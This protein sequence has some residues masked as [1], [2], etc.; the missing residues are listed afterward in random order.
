MDS[1][2]TTWMLVS[3]AF[4]LLMTPGLAFFYGGLVRQRQTVN[5]IKMSFVALGIIAIEWAVLGYSMAFAPGSAV[6]G[7]L[8]FLGLSGVT[9]E[10][11]ARYAEG[12]P[13]LAF[14]A[15]Q[16]M[17]A[18]ITPALI[19]GAVVGRMR[20]KAYALFILLWGIVVYNPVAHWVWGPGGFLREIGALDFAGGTVVHVSAGVSALVVALVLGPRERSSADDSLAEAPHNVPFVILGAAL[21]WFGWFGFNAGSAL[22][23]NGVAALALVTTMLSASAALVTWV[24]V[25]TVRRDKPTATGAAVA[26][27]VGLVAITPGAGFVAP[28][29]AIAVGSIAALAS[30][31]AIEIFKRI[32]RTR[33]DDTLDVFAC[34]GV[35]GIVGCILTGVFATTTVNGAGADGLFY[36][37]GRLLAVQA[38]SVAVAGLYASAATFCVLVLVSKLVP[39]RAPSFAESVGIDVYE[40]AESAYMFQELAFRATNRDSEVLP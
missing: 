22:A 38:L 16:M 9:A 20:F 27:V 40:H 14:M 33:L 17:F 23:A 5:T 35:G 10:V 13:H 19:S 30:Y 29:S 24:V 2:S 37:G 31:G 7:G 36:G 25:E 28:M 4:V 6:L 26:A 8:E 39:L 18:I 21:L 1:G 32:G 11:D 15:F 12:I 34:H 3:I